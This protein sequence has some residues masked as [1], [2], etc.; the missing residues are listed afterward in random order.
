MFLFHLM[1]LVV[2]DCIS[3]VIVF[4]VVDNNDIVDVNSNSNRLLGYNPG[5]L[6][7]VTCLRCY[8]KPVTSSVTNI[9]N[10]LQCKILIDIIIK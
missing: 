9:C 1:L 10:R 6:V 4:F 2:F 3:V 5:Y 7:T 8:T